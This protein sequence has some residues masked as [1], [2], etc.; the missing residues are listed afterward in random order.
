MK[1]KDL[2]KGGTWSGPATKAEIDAYEKA[3][4]VKFPKDYREFL[5]LFGSGHKNGVE[6]AGIHPRPQSDLNVLGRTILQR[7][8]Y[9]HFPQDVIFFSDTG[10]GGQIYLDPKTGEVA[11]V[12]AEPPKGVHKEVIA[13]SF[14]GFLEGRFG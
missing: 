4:A 8:S 3:M 6:I 5:E 9:G 7:R 11:E 2:C 14:S 12:F 13:K 1:T 10:D